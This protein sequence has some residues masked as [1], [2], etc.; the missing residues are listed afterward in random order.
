MFVYVGKD[1]SSDGNVATKTAK[2]IIQFRENNSSARED[3]IAMQT[4]GSSCVAVV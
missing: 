4:A 2:K 1:R 3:P